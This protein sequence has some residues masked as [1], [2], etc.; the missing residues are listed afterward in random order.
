M[1]PTDPIKSA[2]SS[3]PFENPFF[4][5]PL[6]P[7]RSPNRRAPD[8]RQPRRN[9]RNGRYRRRRRGRRL[10]RRRR[11]FL[12]LALDGAQQP[13]CEVTPCL[14]TTEFPETYDRVNVEL[15]VDGIAKTGK[16]GVSPLA[17]L[18]PHKGVAPSSFLGYRSCSTFPR[19]LL[20]E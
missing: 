2:Q 7:K 9:G 20:L 16:L 17:P 11:R 4:L 19:R 12:L 14:P 13:P 10:R 6:A 18:L 8:A 3:L 5:H 15:G 1:H